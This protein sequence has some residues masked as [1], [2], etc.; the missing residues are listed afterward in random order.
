VVQAG[1]QYKLLGKNPLNEMIMA[2]PAIA[3]GSLMV[4]TQSK[5]YRI[6]K[7]LKR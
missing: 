4:R 3:Q 2:S 7:G 6:A 1:P 5:L